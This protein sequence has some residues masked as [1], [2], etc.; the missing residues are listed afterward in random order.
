MSELE[1]FKA[2]GKMQYLLFIIHLIFL[3]LRGAIIQWF[4]PFFFKTTVNSRLHRLL[5]DFLSKTNRPV[6]ACYQYR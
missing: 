6:D 3:H 1:N 5:G 2:N 4:L